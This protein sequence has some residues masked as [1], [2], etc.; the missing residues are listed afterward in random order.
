VATIFLLLTG[1]EYFH[2]QL[3]GTP[4]GQEPSALDIVRVLAGLL[5]V[6]PA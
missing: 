1:I 4:T 6:F 3:L 5:P 2:Y